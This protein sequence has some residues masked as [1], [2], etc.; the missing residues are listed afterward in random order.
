[1]SIITEEQNIIYGDLYA[2]IPIKPQ[3]SFDMLYTTSAKY[4]DDAT[5]NLDKL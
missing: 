2:M 5:F 1:M 4:L 3:G